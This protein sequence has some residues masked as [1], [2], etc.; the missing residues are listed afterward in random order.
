[1]QCVGKGVFA[2]CKIAK[3]EFLTFYTGDL[4]SEKEAIS[5]E[6]QYTEADGS[7]MYFFKHGR[8]MLW[9]VIKAQTQVNRSCC[10][11]LLNRLN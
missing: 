9:L 3:G 6:T 7:Y 11:L 4:I 8:K 5:R 1:M 2:T 10:F